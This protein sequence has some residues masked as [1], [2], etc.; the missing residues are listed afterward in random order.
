MPAADETTPGLETSLTS[1][2]LICVSCGTQYPTTSRSRQKTCFICDDPR[3]YTP[4]AGQSFTTMAALRASGH[5]NIFMPYEPSYPGP[6]SPPSP[7]TSVASSVV[8]S[9]SSPTLPPSDLL[10]NRRHPMAQARPDSWKRLGVSSSSI[11]NNPKAKRLSPQPPKQERYHP[12]GA[13][14]SIVTKPIFAMGQRAI[15]VHTPAG[16]ILWDCITLLDDDTVER[17]RALGGLAAIVISHPHFYTA[18]AEW[19]AAFGCPV[20]LAAE[21][22]KWVALEI[23][24]HVFLGNSKT[25]QIM[26]RSHEIIIEGVRSG[27]IA[28]K[29]GGHF[30]GSMVGHFNGRLLIS[31]TLLTTPAGL[32]GW[33]ADAAGI[34]RS[35]PPGINTFAFM[36]SGPNSIP[37]SVEDISRIWEVLKRYEF[38]STHGAFLGEDIE[39]AAGIKRRVLESIQIQIRRMGWTYNPLLTESAPP[40]I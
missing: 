11:H 34:A 4:A 18:H 12:H 25:D 14:I 17:I 38:K 21:D 3:H 1:Q 20:F 31:D 13:M 28:V 10:I 8:D 36:W 9:G 5:R 33:E 40:Q 32:G 15:L 19:A 37:L 22:R 29:L 24:L 7:T 27:F 16:N 23:P 35:R 30:P 6:M 2:W 26:R 39:D